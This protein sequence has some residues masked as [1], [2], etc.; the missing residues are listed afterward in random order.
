VLALASTD[1]ATISSLATA[2][3]TL[4]LAL[5][6]FASVR[7]ANRSA[8]VSE[9]AL[10]E[11]RR[12]VL[13]QSRLDDPV[14]KIMFVEGRWVRA[15]GG[16]AVADHVDGNVYLAISLRNVGSG[17]GVCQGWTV[18][19]G[20]QSARVLPSHQPE[21]AFRSQS[22]DLYIPAGDVGMWQGALRDRQDPV[23]PVIAAAI[24]AREPITIELLYSDQ[25]GEQRT[26]TRF[27]LTPFGDENDWIA[28]VNRHWYLDR[29]GPRSDADAEAAT[30]Q[31]LQTV[32]SLR[33]KAEDAEDEADAARAEAE[34][35]H[36]EADAA[37][38]AE[39]AT[40]AGVPA[41]A[42]AAQGNGREEAPAE[43]APTSRQ[44]ISD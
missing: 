22:R 20:L 12:P 36:V 30:V 4:V 42:E 7:S 33:E 41:E 25:V 24:D 21:S 1:W 37:R 19:A 18:G 32:E 40:E 44:R 13:V 43:P 8:R 17:I 3:G 10:Q 16:R 38:Q 39:A 27:G 34:A 26:I 23:C 2:G 6:T 11:Q 9:I 14:Q 5:A 15:A 35:A 31:I 29:P 28:S